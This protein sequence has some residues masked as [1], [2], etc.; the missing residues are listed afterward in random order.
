MADAEKPT[1]EPT[2]ERPLPPAETDVLAALDVGLHELGCTWTDCPGVGEWVLR[3]V[4]C[5]GVPGLQAW[6]EPH[7]DRVHV[8]MHVEE[9]KGRTVGHECGAKGPLHDVYQFERVVWQGA[10]S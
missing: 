1:N 7:L 6:C 5:L 10:D 2:S 3:C 8:H 9:A 4:E